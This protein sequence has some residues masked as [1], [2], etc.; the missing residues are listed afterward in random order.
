M[1]GYLYPPYVIVATQHNQST[2]SLNLFLILVAKSP[3][4]GKGLSVLSTSSYTKVA[5]LPDIFTSLSS[6]FWIHGN[7]KNP[8]A[9]LEFAF[10]KL[11]FCAKDILH[12]VTCFGQALL[13]Y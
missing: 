6:L 10:E 1:P 3:I 4:V 5:C 8:L 2:Q 12:R 7:L 11:P 9:Q 13:P